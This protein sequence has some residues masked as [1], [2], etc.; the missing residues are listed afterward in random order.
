MYYL[1]QWE[2]EKRKYYKKTKKLY[3]ILENEHLY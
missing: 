3:I 1:N 2:I